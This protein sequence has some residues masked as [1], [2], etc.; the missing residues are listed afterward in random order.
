MTPWH[1]RDTTTTL[2][3]LENG[4]NEVGICKLLEKLCVLY[5][6]ELRTPLLSAEVELKG[7]SLKLLWSFCGF[8]VHGQVQV[9]SN[10]SS[11]SE[12]RG[13]AGAP[14]K[15]FWVRMHVLYIKKVT[16][17]LLPTSSHSKLV[18]VSSIPTWHVFIVWHT[19]HHQIN[20]FCLLYC[21]LFSC[22]PHR[23]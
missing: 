4:E 18:P 3:Q 1:S 2:A 9:S 8:V 16:F 7:S 10:L 19:S 12:C 21:I 13:P 23:L 5:P 15:N 20:P 6:H 22:Y 11:V 14:P 17:S